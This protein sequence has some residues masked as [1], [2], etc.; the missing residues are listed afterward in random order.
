MSFTHISSFCSYFLQNLFSPAQFC[1]EYPKL[2]PPFPTTPESS[3][4]SFFFCCVLKETALSFST[5][6]I[7]FQ[8]ASGVKIFHPRWSPTQ[9]G[10]IPEMQVAFV[11]HARYFFYIAKCRLQI[12]NTVTRSESYWTDCYFRFCCFDLFIAVTAH[13][14]SNVVHG[15]LL[16]PFIP[17]NNPVRLRNGLVQLSFMTEQGFD[18]W[19]PRS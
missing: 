1:L 2:W 19:S 9:Y 8:A 7:C 11:Q 15:S 16:P 3:A 10:D 18:P 13:F 17:H 6:T 12:L 14:F 5:T 4:L